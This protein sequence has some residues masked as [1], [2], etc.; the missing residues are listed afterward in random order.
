MKI[1]WQ[2]EKIPHMNVK[3]A[4]E[5]TYLT[6]PHLRSWKALSMVSAPPGR[7]KQRNLQFY[8][9]ELYQRR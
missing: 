6:Y 4:G 3:E 9:S 1:K 8:E 2:D 5:V 7:C